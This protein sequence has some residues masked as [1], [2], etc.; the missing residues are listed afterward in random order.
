MAPRKQ[1]CL[2]LKFDRFEIVGRNFSRFRLNCYTP[3]CFKIYCFEDEIFHNSRQ[4]SETSCAWSSQK[5]AQKIFNDI[6][7]ALFLSHFGP[8]GWLLSIST[9]SC[10]P[11][12]AVS[13]FFVE[14]LLA[15]IVRFIS[16]FFQ[17]DFNSKI[18]NALK[19]EM[20]EKKN[21][22]KND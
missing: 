22:S 13:H 15:G 2:F 9:A 10:A 4:I 20:L 19:K 6:S 12:H 17:W 14:I 21:A 3:P 8:I 18:Q 7:N 5:V 11:V 1:F 16:L